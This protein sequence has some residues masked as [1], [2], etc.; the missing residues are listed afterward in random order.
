MDMDLHLLH[1]CMSEAITASDHRPVSAGYG[2]CLNRQV[3]SDEMRGRPSLSCQITFSST[4]FSSTL[5]IPFPWSYMLPT[6][7]SLDISQCTC[8][9][10]PLPASQVIGFKTLP[11]DMPHSTPL[12]PPLLP[13]TDEPP[14]FPPKL[15]APIALKK[16]SSSSA[17]L[18]G[19]GGG[20]AVAFA[21]KDTSL[22][23]QGNEKLGEEEE[24][25]ETTFCP[26]PGDSMTMSATHLCYC[27]KAV[28]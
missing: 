14:E 23:A 1:Y 10:P 17:C 16:H 9:L 22:Q 12:P 3:S 7:V 15:R 20:G 11:Q 25:E 24:G 21:L 28:G 2:L 5:T 6:T 4:S 18:G 19:G 26:T 27:P 8:A 13:I